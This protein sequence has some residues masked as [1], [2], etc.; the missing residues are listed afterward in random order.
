RLQ[1]DVVETANVHVDL[2]GVG[3]RHIERMHATVFAEHVLRDPGVEPIG[4]EIIVAADQL[5]LITRH[6]QVQKS[7]LRPDQTVAVGH[8]SKI[9]ADTKTPPP[10]MASAAKGFHGW[11]LSR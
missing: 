5:E 3:A 9:S 11:P 7:L 6:D 1:I 4:R 2:V 8:P 10:A